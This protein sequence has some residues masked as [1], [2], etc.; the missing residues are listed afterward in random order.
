MHS[1]IEDLQA[2]GGSA[3]SLREPKGLNAAYFS[4]GHNPFQMHER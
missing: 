2:N 1:R 3:K 4:G